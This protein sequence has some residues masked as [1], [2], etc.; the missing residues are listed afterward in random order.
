MNRPVLFLAAIAM[1]TGCSTITTQSSSDPTANIAAFQTYK[2]ESKSSLPP[3]LS[4]SIEQALQESLSATGLAAS[5][6]P[7]LLVNYY[8]VVH[9]EL[10]VTE[11]AVPTLV[12]FRRG[13]TV[14]NTY[15]ADVRQI[16]E[17]MLL[18]D[19]VDLDS[20]KLVWEGSAHGVVSRGNVDRNKKKITQAVAKMFASFPNESREVK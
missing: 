14:W 2:L 10:Q 4:R 9:D 7:D 19:V 13:Y 3:H 11:A 17:G 1:M 5:E 15:E 18:V 8:T 12:T 6:N 16:T 20:N